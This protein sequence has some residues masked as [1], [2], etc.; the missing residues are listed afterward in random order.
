MVAFIK[1][2]NK[3]FSL[4]ADKDKMEYLFCD[5]IKLKA[6]EVTKMLPVNT[7]YQEFAIPVS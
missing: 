6:R 4:Y 7:M 2:K 5:I 3:L 1:L